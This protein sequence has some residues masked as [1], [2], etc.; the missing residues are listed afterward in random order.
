MLKFLMS[1]FLSLSFFSPK[2]SVKIEPVKEMPDLGLHTSASILIEAQSGRVLYE[3]NADEQHYPA[4]MTKM[5]GMYLVLDSI[6]KGKLSFD[7]TVTCSAYASSMGGTQIFLEEGEQMSV[8]D[9]FKAVAINSANDAITALGEHIAGSTENFVR[10]MNETAKDLGMKNTCF[11]NPTGFDDQEHKTTPRD[12]SIVARKLVA[13]GETLF[14]FTRL[15]EAYVREDSAN[16]FWLVNTNKM[17]GHYEG[18]DG[19]KTGYTS[20]AGYNLTATACRNGIRL[21]SVVM[22]EE[23][24]ACRSQDTTTLLNYGFSK[25][26]I[27]HLYPIQHEILRYTFQRALQKDTPIVTKE[28]VKLIVDKGTTK[29]QLKATVKIEK[30]D[31]PVH[32][33]EVVGHLIIEDG[34]GNTYTYALTVLE[35]ITLMRFWDYLKECLLQFL[36]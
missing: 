11:R 25:V 7:D 33:G 20:M 27:I 4:S 35:E 13:Y 15:K 23:S 6:E 19:L 14:Q 31:A 2:P 1:C 28:E 24:I 16:P 3:E 34:L 12:M 17:L 22:H 32:I 10:L 29:E 9:L 30:L 21:I 5:M 26:D 18:M 8:R 36:A